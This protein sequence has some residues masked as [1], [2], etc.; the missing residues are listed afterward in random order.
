M[1]KAARQGCLTPRNLYGFAASGALQNQVSTV[2]VGLS[3]TLAS[4]SANPVPGFSGQTATAFAQATDQVSQITGT[5]M[6][7]LAEII[8][9]LSL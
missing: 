5:E 3:E 8:L 1:L 7:Q 4:A 6:I 9:Q 2:N